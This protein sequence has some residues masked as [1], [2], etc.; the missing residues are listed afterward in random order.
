[1]DALLGTMKKLPQQVF[2]VADLTAEEK[3]LVGER[4]AHC[5]VFVFYCLFFSVLR[6]VVVIH[7]RMCLFNEN[8][9]CAY[10]RG[11]G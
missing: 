8:I 6:F 7:E 9:S 2:M 5:D 10:H 1:M 3:Q 4:G 11:G